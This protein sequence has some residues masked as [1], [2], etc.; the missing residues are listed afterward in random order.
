MTRTPLKQQLQEGRRVVG[1]FLQIPSP[2]IVELMARAGLDFV[3]IDLE[4][5]PYGIEAA[6]N[7]VR[8]AD[9]AGVR[10]LVRVPS[11]DPIYILKALDLGPDGLIIPQIRSAEDAQ[12][13]VAAAKY[14]PEGYRGACPCVRSAG[15]DAVNNP[16]YYRRANAETLMVM[17]IEGREAVENLPAIMEVEGVDVVY[18]GAV[19]LSHSL[20]V[21]GQVDHPRV[22]E[23]IRSAVEQGRRRGVW[24]GNFV[25]D[26]AEA[27]EWFAAGVQFLACSVDTTIFL[28]ALRD[29][30]AAA[31]GG[32]G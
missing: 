3:V 29:L 26:P 2:V 13:A 18:M 9:L 31:R 24:T 12:A 28:N 19:D 27:P 6:E 10:P 30:A 21:P 23:A 14:A 7:L 1:T 5:G 25:L 20:G 8:V 4:H 22:R 16:D 32:R 11:V 17:L 15:Y